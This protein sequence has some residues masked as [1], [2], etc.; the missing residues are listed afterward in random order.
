MRLHFIICLLITGTAIIPA[1]GQDHERAATTIVLT[2]TGVQNLG[3]QTVEVEEQTFEETVFALGHIEIL[4]GKK[5]VV[6][7]RIAGRA[8]SVLALPDQKVEEGEEV[9]WVESR[10][11]GDPPPTVMLQAPI[12]GIISKV[13]IATGQPVEP[14]HELIEIIN[15]DQVEAAAQVPQHLAERL[16]VGQKAYIKIQGSQARTFEATLA[17]LGAYADEEAGTIE[18]AFHLP[19]PDHLLRPGMRAEFNI[20]VNVRENVMAVPRTAL[21]GNAV[22]RHVY[23]KDFDLPNAFL[24]TPVVDGEINADF[25]EIKSGLFPADEVVTHGAYSLGFAGGGTVSLKE[26]LDAA[27]GHEHN[28]DGS[29]KTPDQASASGAHEH[30]HEHEGGRANQVF[31]PVALFFAATTA[32]L[33]VLLIVSASKRR[34]PDDN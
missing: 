25:V 3:I 13:N 16:K 27:H 14:T 1:A 30:E 22:D 7:S 8:Y 18:A 6:S 10:Q 5:A 31:S 15:L 33:L 32:L 34:Q 23:V 19:N 4:P 20:I 12:E 9:M 17:H 11:P 26:A 28:E 21:L 2:E 24:K 29:E